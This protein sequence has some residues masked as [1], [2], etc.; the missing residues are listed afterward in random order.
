MAEKPDARY[1]DLEPGNEFSNRVHGYPVP[2]TIHYEWR[3]AVL[4]SN[5]TAERVQREAVGTQSTIRRMLQAPKGL[6][7]GNARVP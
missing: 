6:V 3:T 5:R 7:G 2:A 4:R 1:Q